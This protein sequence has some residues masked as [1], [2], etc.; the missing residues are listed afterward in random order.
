MTYDQ[1]HDALTQLSDNST[2]REFARAL[3]NAILWIELKYDWVIGQ[4]EKKGK[5]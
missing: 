3:D 2:E 5:P 1:L 4:L